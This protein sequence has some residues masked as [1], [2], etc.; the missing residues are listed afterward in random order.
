M[1]RVSLSFCHHG[2][3]YFPKFL[4]KKR[5]SGNVF[6]TAHIPDVRAILQ[7]NK[8]GDQSKLF[9]PLRNL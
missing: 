2:T 5:N 9:Q 6:I 3:D 4:N 7:V 8:T 1:F